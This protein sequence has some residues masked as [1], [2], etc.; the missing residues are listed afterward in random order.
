MLA[1]PLDLTLIIMIY[2]CTAQ[3]WPSVMTA[4][5]QPRSLDVA[6]SQYLVQ[7]SGSDDGWGPST[8]SNIILGVIMAFIGLIALWQSH[9]RQVLS[10]RDKNNQDLELGLTGSPRVSDAFLPQAQ[11][12][13]PI[14][15]LLAPESTLVADSDAATIHDPRAIEAQE[16]P[17][18]VPGPAA[19]TTY[20]PSTALEAQEPVRMHLPIATGSIDDLPRSDAHAQ[21]LG[22][23][24]SS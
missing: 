10:I 9:R 20:Q 4:P 19:A 12:P 1:I 15:A 14:M 23:S 16:L 11:P 7:N 5:A 6:T 17:V 24:H 3:C 22:K 2:F 21:I 18:L 8:V 13:T